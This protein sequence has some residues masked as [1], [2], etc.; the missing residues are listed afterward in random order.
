MDSSAGIKA[1]LWETEGPSLTLTSQRPAHALLAQ[2][3]VP[4]QHFA[5]LPETGHN[6]RWQ[7]S[8]AGVDLLAIAREA[9]LV[10]LAPCVW[11]RQAETILRVLEKARVVVEVETPCP[12]GRIFHWNSRIGMRDLFLSIPALAGHLPQSLVCHDL[13]QVKTAAL[14]LGDQDLLIK[15]NFA[16]GG[17]GSMLLPA[18][19]DYD[20]DLVAGIAARLPD[21]AKGKK[22]FDWAWREEPFV[23]EAVVGELKSNLSVTLD[24]R[25]SAAGT[26]IVGISE[27]LIDQ[28]FAYHGI[29]SLGAKWAARHAAALTAI[30]EA[31]GQALAARGFAGWF[32][33]DFVLTRGGQCFLVDLN[34]RRSAPLDLHHLVARVGQ[35]AGRKLCYQAWERF[36]TAQASEQAVTCVLEAHGLAF[37]GTS[38]VLPLRGPEA[39]AAGGHA[40][41]VLLLAAD[42]AALVRLAREFRRVL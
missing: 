40:L 7:D 20:Q 18:G 3:L 10:R 17:L 33:L 9:G 32:N 14:R 41:P 36:E 37:D 4:R 31:T 42:E 27:Q 26:E 38:G 12:H 23:I 6:G 8:E 5:L 1:A 15:S 21:Q 24:A 30:A 16:L 29:R 19:A 2:G 25:Q 22:A 34:V 13:A 35:R 28:G 39:G 11:T